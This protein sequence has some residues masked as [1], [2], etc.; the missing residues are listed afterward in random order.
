MYELLKNLLLREA[1]ILEELV[2][3]QEH[4]TAKIAVQTRWE[5]QIS[6]HRTDIGLFQ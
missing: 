5:V 3:T 1:D 6:E 2:L 4:D